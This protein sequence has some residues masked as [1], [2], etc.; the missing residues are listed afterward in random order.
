MLTNFTRAFSHGHTYQGHPVSCAAALE[1]QRIIRE[2]NLVANVRRLGV[3]LSD[4]LH[5][6]LDSHPYVGDVRGKGLFWGVSS[7][8]SSTNL[9]TL[10]PSQIEFVVDKKTKEPFPRAKNVANAVHAVALHRYGISLYPGMG[11]KDGIVGDHVLVC[12]AYNSTEAEIR[13]IVKK[14]KQTVD[15]AFEGIERGDGDLLQAQPASRL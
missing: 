13:D 8:S 3:I 15:V 12:P 11:T 9:Q 14:V 1:V 7:S 6:T 5:Q 10:T 2:D 4:L